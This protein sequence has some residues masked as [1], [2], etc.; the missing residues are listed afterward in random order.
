MQNQYREIWKTIA[1]H[2]RSEIG[3]DNFNRW[4]VAVEMEQLDD[5]QLV[6][7]VP[8]SIHEFFIESNYLPV[9]NSAI[10]K[11]LGNSRI[12]AF[13]YT[14]VQSNNADGCLEDGAR[15]TTGLD[16][17]TLE[18]SLQAN[19]RAAGVQEGV[20]SLSAARSARSSVSNPVLSSS[21][22]CE[23][24]GEIAR[25]ADMH[26]D[27]T[28]EEFVVGPSNEFAHA[29]ARAVATTPGSC[30]NPFLIYG[31]PGVGKTHLIQAIAIHVMQM[32]PKL[33]VRYVS[34]EAF[35]NEY[36]EALRDGSLVKFRNRMRKVDVLLIDDIQFL[37]GKDRSQE[38][39]F[40][41]FN[42]LMSGNHQIVLSSDRNAREISNLQSRLMS[43]LEWG[44]TAE[45]YAPDGETRHAILRKKAARLQVS[46]CDKVLD[47]LASRIT[48]NV[49]RLEGALNRVASFISLNGEE[50]VAEDLE[51]IVRDYLVDEAVQQVSADDVL[52]EVSRY[53]QVRVQDLKGPRRP[54]KIARSRQVA[55]YL[56]RE[57]TDL[58]LK[59][60]GAEFGGRDHATV[61][62]AC[63]TITRLMDEDE[64]L[65][66]SVDYLR[67]QLSSTA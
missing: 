9:L 41:T 51:E 49:R 33:S 47:F 7:A 54:A 10:A 43:R 3:E 36:I 29:A 32:A 44:L 39:F 18:E 66:R 64:Q 55:M 1:D 16:G 17:E 5:E 27:Y 46:I 52:N 26:P 14:T 13:R 25:R 42:S 50:R 57:L 60:I 2:L 45:L 63:R 40:H 23:E 35:V 34:S 24:A 31:A 21:P 53:Y 56:T 12:V 15:P 6:L 67:N 65:R 30:Y 62:H 59:E 20:V 58:S 38:E 37:S 48:R 11:E 19:P 4:F 61:L 22:S 8:N 28:F